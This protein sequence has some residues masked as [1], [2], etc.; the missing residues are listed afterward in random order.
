MVKAAHDRG[1]REF[2]MP[3]CSE[4][5]TVSD[6]AEFRDQPTPSMYQVYVAGSPGTIRNYCLPLILVVFLEYPY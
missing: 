5:V 1:M 2:F 3:H 4:R 6:V